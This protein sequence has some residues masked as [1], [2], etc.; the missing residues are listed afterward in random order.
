MKSSTTRVPRFPAP[1]R[2]E[3]DDVPSSRTRARAIAELVAHRGVDVL[4]G[5]LDRL[6]DMRAQ[7][8][9]AA[10]MPT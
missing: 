9:W 1:A 10:A 8:T 3:D 5:L 7:R 6:D 4:A 2:N